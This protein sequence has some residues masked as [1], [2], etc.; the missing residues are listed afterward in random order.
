M[1][2][3]LS[4]GP[5]AVSAGGRT[6]AAPSLPGEPAATRHAARALR[7]RTQT[8]YSDCVLRLGRRDGWGQ[9]RTR[10]SVGRRDD[11]QVA[12]P[13]GAVADRSG[14]GRHRAVLGGALW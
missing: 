11:A 12:A 8:A 2:T 10:A 9:Q 13:A 7:L 1:R 5:A 6:G 14:I 4:T 3:S